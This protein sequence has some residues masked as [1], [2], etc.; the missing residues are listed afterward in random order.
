[1]NKINPLVVLLVLVGILVVIGGFYLS[2]NNQNAKDLQ[3]TSK[4]GEEVGRKMME[5]QSKMSQ[6]GNATDNHMTPP[7]GNHMA[8]PMGRPPSP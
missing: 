5:A 3:E 4:R 8:P 2:H 6:G 1:M 7:S